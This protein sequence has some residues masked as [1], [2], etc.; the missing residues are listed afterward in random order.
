[1][2]L[3]A[4]LNALKIVKS[5]QTARLAQSALEGLTLTQKSS[6]NSVAQPPALFRN[7][8]THKLANA[9][10]TLSILIAGLRPVKC[11]VKSSKAAQF[12]MKIS[13]FIYTA[14]LSTVMEG[15]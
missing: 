7:K 12:A 6:A 13:A 8:K 1:M 2:A 5:V 15:R 4:A 10:Q 14:K 9:L 11:A 3:L